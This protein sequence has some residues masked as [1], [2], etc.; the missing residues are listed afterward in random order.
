MDGNAKHFPTT[1]KTAKLFGLTT[2]AFRPIGLNKHDLGLADRLRQ[3]DKAKQLRCLALH[4]KTAKLFSTTF[5]PIGL[6]KHNI[7]AD[8]L[9]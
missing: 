3:V 5:R 1:G 7:L 6:N 4:N 8:R 2:T 9:K